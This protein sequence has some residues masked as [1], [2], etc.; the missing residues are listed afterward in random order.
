M[1]GCVHPLPKGR[2]GRSGGRW[3]QGE[4]L[5]AEDHRSCQQRGPQQGDVGAKR[6]TLSLHTPSDLHGTISGARTEG[7]RQSTPGD[8][9]P[10]SSPGGAVGERGWSVA[11]EDR[12]GHNGCTHS[13]SRSPHRVPSWLSPE[14]PPPTES[15][16]GT[17]LC[18]EHSV[19]E[20]H[21]RAG[22]SDSLSPQENQT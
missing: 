3:S 21:G 12:G 8:P 22:K 9:A 15:G 2:R 1:G 7:R 5:R 14:S 4:G 20:P 10:R 19:D 13:S 17:R 6:I 16:L 18:Y 11:L